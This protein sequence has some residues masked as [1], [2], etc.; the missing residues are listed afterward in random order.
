MKKN[1]LNSKKLSKR[2]LQYGALSAA[3]LGVA[4]A[5]GQV[6]YVDIDPDQ[7]INVGEDF[8]IDFTEDGTV[9]VIPSNPSGLA[10]GN[11][12]IVFPSSGGAFVGITAGSFEYPALLAEGAVIDGAANFT[13][14]GVRGDL[15]YYGCAYSNSQWCD[16]VTDGYL[17]VSFQFSGNTHYAWVRMDTDVN[18]SNVMTIKDFAYDA[19]PGAAI[20]AGDIGLSVEDQVFNGFTYFID[21]NSQLNLKANAPLQSVS[22]HNIL[23]QEVVSQKL[24]STNEIVNLSAL[25]SGVYLATISIDGAKKTVKVAKK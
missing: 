4:E 18:G 20:A 7:V 22:I 8:E 5:N 6:Q 14:P 12:A 3:A 19:T 16:E 21:K 15:N 23:G 25:K 10:N 9:N 17:G 24:G 2:L 11:A 13:T 1:T